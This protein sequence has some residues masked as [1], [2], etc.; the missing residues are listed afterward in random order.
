MYSRVVELGFDKVA[1]TSVSL[2]HLAMVELEVL[3]T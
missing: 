1:V 3:E 2:P